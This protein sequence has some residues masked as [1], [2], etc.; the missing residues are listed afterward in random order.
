MREATERLAA[1]RRRLLRAVPDRLPHLVDYTSFCDELAA[2]IGCKPTRA[3]VRR[4]RFGFRARF[5][6]GP[7]VAAQYRLVGPHAKPALAR[8]VIEGLPIRHPRPMLAAFCLR[9]AASRALGRTIGKDFAPK[10]E[11]A[12]D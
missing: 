3:A 8:E 10:L 6:A 7:F 9:W 4:E 11:L 5:Y 1:T 12:R 2:R